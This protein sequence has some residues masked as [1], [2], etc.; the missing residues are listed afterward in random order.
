MKTR[1]FVA[2]LCDH[3]HKSWGLYTNPPLDHST[4]TVLVYPFAG[5]YTSNPKEI[6]PSIIYCRDGPILNFASDTILRYNIPI[7]LRPFQG[8][9]RIYSIIIMH[10][11]TLQHFSI[12]NYKSRCVIKMDMDQKEDFKKENNHFSVYINLH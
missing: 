8:M 7:F 6:V 3:S 1:I 2:G 10:A 11:N 4:H 12:K 9:F 5:P